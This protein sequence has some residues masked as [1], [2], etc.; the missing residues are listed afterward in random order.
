MGKQRS[1]DTRRPRH[2]L[3]AV[4]G[5]YD[6]FFPNRTNKLL[7]FTPKLPEAVLTRNNELSL[8]GY[9]DAMFSSRPC[10]THKF[11]PAF[12]KQRWT[13]TQCLC[14]HACFFYCSLENTEDWHY[15]A[16]L[17]LGQHS[18]S[19]RVRIHGNSSAVQ[20]K[21]QGSTP[22]MYPLTQHSCINLITP[23]SPSL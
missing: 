3:T 1:H 11:G 9:W 15:N 13:V 4:Y 16:L 12:Q 23:L 21:T 20:T 7:T 18:A 17:S 2:L 14:V 5:Y 10:Q 6:V 8:Q 19:W 22:F